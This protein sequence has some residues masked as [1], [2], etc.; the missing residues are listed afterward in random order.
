M[1]DEKHQETEVPEEE[2]QV[3]AVK[4]DVNGWQFDRRAFLAVAGAAAASA[5]VGTAAGCGAPRSSIMIR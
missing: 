1:K 2:P 3:Y 4:K 5:A